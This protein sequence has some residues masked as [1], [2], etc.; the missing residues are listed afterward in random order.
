MSTGGILVL[1]GYIWTSAAD[2]QGEYEHQYQALLGAGVVAE[3]IYQDVG[4]VYRGPR[5]QLERCL[6]AL[7]AADIL[8]TPYLDSLAHG[9]SNLLAVLQDLAARQV[10][11]RVLTGKAAIIDTAQL[12]LSL[13]T[14]V[15]EALVEFEDRTVRAAR[16]Q[17]IAAARARGQAFGPKR[18]MTAGIIRQAMA[19]MANSDMSVTKIAETLGVTRSS[20]YTYLNG[21]GSPKSSALQLLAAEEGSTDSDDEAAAA[22]ISSSSTNRRNDTE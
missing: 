22:D 1:V 16:E 6:Q 17:G 13:V 2:D 18:K 14:A 9:R 20:L 3:H 21:D 10:G 19:Y 15:I 5:P 11:L 4:C 8:V 7:K 12:R